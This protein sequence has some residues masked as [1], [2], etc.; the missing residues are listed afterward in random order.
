[1]KSLRLLLIIALILL[2]AVAVTLVGTGI[3]MA[4][5]IKAIAEAIAKA[6]GWYHPSGT[7]L[8][9]RL[10]NPGNLKDASG[11]LR[12]FDTPQDGWNAL[13]RQVNL[14][15]SGLSR[16]YNPDMTIEQVAYLYTGNDNP[17]AWAN[18]VSQQLG[19]DPSTTLRN[20]EV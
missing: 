9:Q 2:S 20:I 13:Y 16:V 17:N 7:A 6:E 14:M 18:I 19:V 1:M 12:T 15:V 4:D 5:K 11:K 8:P 3:I 10:N